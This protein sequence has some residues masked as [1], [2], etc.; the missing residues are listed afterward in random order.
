MKIPKGLKI[1]QVRAGTGP[2]AEHGKFAL[3]H[4]DCYLPR[5]EKCESSRARGPVQLKVGERR[6]YP[7]L[8]Y[9][10]P[11]MA[12]VKLGRSKLVL[13]SPITRGNRIRIYL[14]MLRSDMRLNFSALMISGTIPFTD[15]VL[16]MNRLPTPVEVVSS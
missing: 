6:T 12:L 4:Y 7:A 9:A 5:G 1:S 3:I 8:A 2:V 14:L 10:L 15:T 16:A 11:G 13:I